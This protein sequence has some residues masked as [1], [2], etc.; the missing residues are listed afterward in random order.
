MTSHSTAENQTENK[1]ENKSAQRLLEAFSRFRRLGWRQ[2]PIEGVSH[3]EFMIIN[4]IKRTSAETGTGMRVSEISNILQ[5]APPTI[6]Q[7]LNNL[8]SRD[9]IA[10]QIDKED[11]RVIRVSLTPSGLVLVEKAHNDFIASITGLVDYL[12]EQDSNHLSDLLAKVYDY[13]EKFPDTRV[14]QPR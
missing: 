7:Q 10:R 14:R 2:T 11:R 12:G 6:T 4:I 3:S 5:V 13:F 9:Y 1:S 8:E